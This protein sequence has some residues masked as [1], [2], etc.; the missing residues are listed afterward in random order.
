MRSLLMTSVLTLASTLILAAEPAKLE[1]GKYNV[2]PAH[3]SVGF[4]IPHLV[5]STVE[6]KF[7]TF[8][9]VLNVA[10]PFTKSTLEAEADIN[11]VDTSVADRDTHLKSPDF[12]D[13]AK[14]P[15]MTFKST[16]ITGNEKSFKLIGDLTIKGTTKKVTFDSVYKGS[17]TDAYGNLKAAFVAT[18]KISRKEFGL[19]WSKVVEVGPVVGDEV[20]ITLKIQ[21]AKEVAK[22]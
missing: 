6:G 7:K 4:E 22:K 20:T 10:S 14:F 8:T 3:S 11:S 16:S 9:G 1:T 2:D 19:T 18:T 21:A 17:A 5:I 13:A 15:K 12:F